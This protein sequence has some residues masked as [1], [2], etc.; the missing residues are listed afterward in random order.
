MGTIKLKHCCCILAVLFSFQS[1]IAQY[2]IN[3]DAGQESCNWYRLTHGTMGQHGSVWNNNQIDLTQSFDYKFDVILDTIGV[4]NDGGADGI[5]FVLQPISTSVGGQGSGLGFGGI[6]PSVGVTI[7]TYQN[8]IPDNDPFYDHI[9]VQLNG[10]LNHLSANNIAGPVTALAASNN[11]EDGVWHSLRIQWDALTTTLTVSMDGSVRLNVIRDFVN[12]VFSGNPMVYW[13]FTGSTGA[14]FNYQAFKTA[15]NPSFHFA[16][17]QHKCVNEPITFYDSTISFT[18]LAKL[19]WDFGDG[20]PIDSIDV[21]PV[22]TYTTAGTYTVTQTVISADGC[23]AVNTQQVTIGSK[24]VASFTYSQNCMPSASVPVAFADASTV[25]GSTIGTWYWDLNNSQTATT[26]TATAT[27]PGPGDQLIK[28]V[29]ASLEGCTSDTLYKTIHVYTPPVADFIFN[30]SA[31]LGSPTTFS[32]SVSNAVGDSGIINLSWNIDGNIQLTTVPVFTTVFATPGLHTVTLTAFHPYYN[33][34]SGGNACSSVVQKQVFIVDKPTAHFTYNNICQAATTTFTDSSYTSDGTPINQWWW[35]LGAGGISTQQNPP[36]VYPISGN[37]TIRL[38]VHN[39][40]GCASDTLK[41]PIVINPKP[42]ANFG[43]STPVCT[44]QNIAFTD[45]SSAAAQT[46]TGWSWIYNGTV[47]GTAST[48]TKSFTAGNQTVQLVATSN[49]GC[50]SDTVAKTF[51]VNPSPNVTIN[52]KD[53]CKNAVVNFTATDN[54]GTVTSWKWLFGDGASALTQNAQH[55]YTANGNYN[56]KLYAAASNGCYSDSLTGLINI[57]S[58]NVFAGNDTIAAAGQPVQL[59]AT[60]GL[61][62]TWTPALPLNDPNIAD[63]IAILNNTQTFT[64]KAFTPEGCESY[65]D[66]TVKIYNG[67]EIYLPTAFTPNGDGAND[68]FRGIPVGIK[69]FNY[70]K[71]FNRWGEMVFYTNDYNVGWDGTYKGQKQ[72]EGVYVVMAN[73]ID[74][75]G[76]VIN[77]KATVMLIK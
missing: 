25:T 67:P 44:Q 33:P 60:G 47:F 48:A 10:D 38:V 14:L 4:P 43:Y 52:F 73:G 2:T 41:Q 15:L 27:Y 39:A 50:V 69:Q 53:A 37:D 34:G 51:Y 42:T 6:S 70:L 28:L 1:A 55:T 21:N 63:P 22:H 68:I 75:R 23:T 12:T 36:G 66:I 19:Y 54:T 7:D 18:N 62:Y 24:P 59:H 11:I 72:P 58:T 29:V 30:D 56:V 65:D 77:K 5:A 3:G 49:L 35:N 13:G 64:V 26:A 61:S 17:G 71:V 46:I 8:T 31:C 40:K 32:A 20:S 9:A 57:Y 74:F 45:S 76:N 16:P